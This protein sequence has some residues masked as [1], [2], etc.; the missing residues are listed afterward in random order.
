VGVWLQVYRSMEGQ[1]D[2]RMAELVNKM[3]IRCDYQF[4]EIKFPK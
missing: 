2:S 3:T 4:S 1:M